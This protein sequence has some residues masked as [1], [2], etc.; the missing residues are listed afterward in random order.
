MSVLDGFRLALKGLRRR[1]LQSALTTLGIT[2]GVAAVLTMV[3][4]G[5][6]ARTAI[7]RHVRTSGTNIVTVEAGNYERF[8]SSEINK[9][10]FNLNTKPSPTTQTKTQL[11]EQ[12]YWW[13]T[14]THRP[15]LPGQG[16][17]T[18][19]KIQDADAIRQIPNVEL[20]TLSVE[21]NAR[22]IAGEHRHFTRLK[23][24][25]VNVMQMHGWELLH[26]RFFNANEIEEGVPVVVLGI[27]VSRFLFG[28]D[29]NPI[30]Q[31]IDV[32]GKNFLVIGVMDQQ[33]RRAEASSDAIYVPFT[34]AQSLLNIKHLHHLEIST[35]S[36]GVTSQVATEVAE[37][38]R[39]RHQL[40]PNQA[41]DFRIRTQVREALFGKGLAPN[42]RRSVIG[43]VPT[44]DNLVIKEMSLTLEQA[45]RTM[46]VLLIA[47]ASV[48][49]FV[50][51]IGIM[52]I[53]LVST[54]D[55]TREIGVRRMV[56]ARERDVLV[57]FLL[58]AVLLSACGGGFG[59]LVGYASAATLT[60]AF[61]WTSHIPLPAVLL[62]FITSLTVGV[63]FGLY[64]ARLA[65]RIDIVK[66]LHEN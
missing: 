58:E 15:V 49:L 11:D 36:A 19:L 30:G 12:K 65:S 33:K 31:Q 24:V 27:A 7:S 62:T 8:A 54:S 47:I 61:G 56:G 25:D 6:G 13:P 40:K 51:G 66:I 21:D 45:G 46:S 53:M 9:S 63:F 50:G 34:T 4:L 23:G 64:P 10:T 14:P 44:Y 43:N 41:D 28:E 48:A 22:I 18:N 57:Q 2:F 42:L 60:H 55:R 20:V 5:T 35:T 1:K 16:A 59:V 52:N 17:S 37:L 26:G 38:L 29:I 3:A 32:Q 39:K